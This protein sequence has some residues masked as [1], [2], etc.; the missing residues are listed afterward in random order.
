M[1]TQPAP[2]DCRHPSSTG[3][4]GIY[5]AEGEGSSKALGTRGNMP[6]PSGNHDDEKPSKGK[7]GKTGGAGEHGGDEV[8][9]PPAQPSKEAWSKAKAHDKSMPAAYSPKKH[10]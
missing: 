9:K 5:L 6:R 4:A 3:R 10:K 2:Q 7:S 1:H 8:P